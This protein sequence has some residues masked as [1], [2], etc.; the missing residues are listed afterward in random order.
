VT[1]HEQ[2]QRQPQRQPVFNAPPATLWTCGVL[3]ICHI[4]FSLAG[5]GWQHAALSALGYQPLVFLAQFE[6]GGAGPSL[7]GILP[8]FG[9]VL[10]HGDLMHLLLNTGFLL[11]F[12][13]AVERRLGP[14]LFLMVFA[15]T[16]AGGAL[17]ETL[18]VEQPVLMIGASGA[19]YGMMGAVLPFLFGPAMPARRR[20]MLEFV[21]VIMAINL[22]L[23]A[24]GLGDILAGAEIAWRAHIGGFAVGLAL[25]FALAARAPR[26]G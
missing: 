10:L 17:A 18:F 20:R 1:P 13:S 15:A 9:H 24:F 22:L 12:G 5:P 14:G 21:A 6:A 4:V 2:P 11:A 7:L 19:V 25:S 8:L 16:A 3:I 23:G 26:R